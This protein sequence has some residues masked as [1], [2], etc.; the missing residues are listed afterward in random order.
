[1][2]ES[3]ADCFAL[4]DSTDTG[5]LTE[6]YPSDQMVSATA[7]DHYKIICITSIRM[8]MLV[9]QVWQNRKYSANYVTLST[10]EWV[11]TKIL[12]GSIITNILC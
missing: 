11:W 8:Y 4:L 1:M 7:D 2:D 5:S 12:G 9:S 3:C 6:M 10:E